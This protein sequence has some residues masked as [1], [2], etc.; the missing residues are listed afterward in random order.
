MGTA[1]KRPA[2]H[3]KRPWALVSRHA[4]LEGV[5]L[6]DMRHYFAAFGGEAGNVRPA[7]W[8]ARRVGVRQSSPPSDL[9][10]SSDQQRTDPAIVPLKYWAMSSE[11]NRK[12][13]DGRHRGAD[14]G[15]EDRSAVRGVAG[16]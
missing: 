6:H 15:P 13:A 10:A 7:S 14:E 16:T 1:K 8:P 12:S 3:L 11:V 5:R 4:G 2:A 9:P